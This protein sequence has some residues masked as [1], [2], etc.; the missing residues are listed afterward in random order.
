MGQRQS[1]DEPVDAKWVATNAVEMQIWGRIPVRMQ[2]EKQS[3]NL[4]FRQVCKAWD[5]SL[6][7]DSGNLY[8]LHLIALKD[9]RKLNT[10]Q[11]FGCSQTSTGM[12]LILG[13]SSPS[14]NS[15]SIILKSN[16]AIYVFFSF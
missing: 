10:A 7:R 11:F 12:S 6:D 2:K 5:M 8:L 4:Q 16:L 13:S 3:W 14:K 1:C 15:S 9:D